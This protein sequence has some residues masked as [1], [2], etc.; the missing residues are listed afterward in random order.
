MV[1]HRERGGSTAQVAL[2]SSEPDPGADDLRGLDRIV[3]R[4]FELASN[5][6]RT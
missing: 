1:R 5:H 6:Y 4:T 2:R 3:S